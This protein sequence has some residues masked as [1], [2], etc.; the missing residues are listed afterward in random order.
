L[1]SAVAFAIEVPK[2]RL[3]RILSRV[4]EFDW[5]GITELGDWSAGMD[6]ATMRRIATHWLDGYDWRKE[7]ARLNRLPQFVAEID[8]QMLHFVHI[9]SGGKAARPPVLLLHGWP[10]SFDE[11]TQVAEI[12]S[13]PARFGGDPEDG[14]DVII[15]SLP[16]YGF[17]TGLNRSLSARDI[18]RLMQGL[19]TGELGYSRY[20]AQGGDWGSII[21]SWMAHDYPQ[22]CAGLH[23]NLSVLECG[24][25]R[26]QGAEEIA[27]KAR[28]LDLHKSEGGY[29]HIQTT[30]PQT[31]SFALH[32]SPIGTA[33]W[34]LEKFANWSDLP[35]PGGVPD[36]EAAYRLDHLITNVMI[37]LVSGTMGSA[38]SLY[39]NNAAAEGFTLDHPVTVPTAM[40]AFPD[41]VFPPPPRSL[42]QRSFNIQ[43]W[44]DMPTGGHFAAMERPA[45]FASDVMAFMKMLG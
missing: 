8:G 45:D 27:Y 28:K 33:A 23:L 21:A 9:R 31:L 15:P 26:P 5:D 44:T 36:L 29:A 7:E 11:F 4:A 6:I 1:A 10:G 43:R 24:G 38:T 20:V 19:M 16:G 2:T 12:L 41:P 18:A 35:R 17:S 32:D 42:M 22:S 30:R 37:Y 39:R 40:A 13:A 34:I 14:V 25:V 3:S